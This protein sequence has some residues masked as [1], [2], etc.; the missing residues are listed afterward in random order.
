M[1]LEKIASKGS[2]K[3]KMVYHENPDEL[4]IN[5]LE[6]HAYFIPFEKGQDPFASRE[7]SNNF[8]L[9]NG[10]WGFRYF[11]S[12]ID[13]E[14]DFTK[15]AAENTIPVPA[16]WQLHGYDK[17][18]Y[19]NIAYPITFDP[20]Y[21][22]DENPVG[23]YS[24]EYEYIP[25]GKDRILVFEGVDSCLYLYV[26]DIFTGYSQVSH[27][28]SEFDITP[29]LVTGKNKITVAV[30]KWCDGTYLEDQD[31]Y[32]M[33][34]IFRD[35]YVLKRPVKRI[36][37]YVVKTILNEEKTAADLEVSVFGMDVTAKLLDPEGNAI[38]S[39]NVCDGEKGTIHVENPKLWS[40]EVP[41]LYSLMITAGEELIGEKVG[42][43]DIAIRNGVVEINGIPVK[44]RGVNRH[45]SYPDTGFYCTAE[46]M[47]MDIVLMKKHNVNA[48]RTSHYP[49]S[50]L[51]Y[52]L[53]DQYGLYVIDEGDM[54]THGCVEV[55]NDFKW[56]W[57]DGY[58]GI[59]LLASDERFKKAI[60]DRSESLVKRDINRPC[61]VF[62]SLGNESG[63]G[64]NMEAAGKLVKKLDD[65]RLLH[66]EST[67]KLDD[68]SDAVLDVVSQMY[69][70]PEDMNKFLE[71]E[72]E[73]RPF[74]LCEY[75]H[76]MGNGPG[77]LEDYHNAFHS[78]ERFCGGFVWE[79]CDHAPILGTTP[80]GKV[81]YGYGGDF[82][83]RHHDNNFCMDAL[84]YPD[85]RPHTGLLELKQVYRPIRV[86]MG[87]SATEFV[88]SSLLCQ[89]N[90]GD[91]MDYYYEISF[92]GGIT[93]SEST[94]FEIA[95]LGEKVVEVPDVLQ[96]ADKEA[97]IRFVFTAKKALTYCEKGYEICFDQ[98]ELAA[99]S[100]LKAYNEAEK[101]CMQERLCERTNAEGGNEEKN[102]HLAAK[103]REEVL[104]IDVDF[105]KVSYSY[106]RRKCCFDSIRYEGKELL[107]EAMN[108]NFFRAPI[109][110]DTMR[111]EWYRA[112]L[113]D[114]VVKGYDA[115]VSTTSRGVEIKQKQSFGWS[116]HQPIAYMD[117]VYILNA[118]GMDIYCELETGNK[119]TFLPRFGVRLF[120][121]KRFDRV[122]YYGYGPFE[123]YIDK[124]QASYMGNFEADICD[125]YED[126][127]KPQENSSHFGCK[128]V[129][130]TDGEVS[131]SFTSK[132]G[133]SFNASEYTQE[134]LATKRHNFDLVKSKSNILCVDYMMAGV[135]SNSCGPQ[136]NE[137]Y[138]LPLPMLSADFHMTID[139]L[140]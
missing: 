134:E 138:R 12:V 83:E 74:I 124:H 69:T 98:I 5:T 80:D 1:N 78:N 89:S 139:K 27:C 101:N 40:A 93:K 95:P 104:R 55:Y 52:Q 33:S 28:T 116:I 32:R 129:S 61:V 105:G 72:D 92:D 127:I 112:H 77:D 42:F 59:A 26:N 58:N 110:N 125:M 41:E 100:E 54:E 122:S 17:P 16:N 107:D 76:A 94:E 68:T 29:Y 70:S 106:N 131:L 84:T 53:C 113:N 36:Q 6:K 81:M 79:W 57:A 25:D 114:Y 7:K 123:S 2:A 45:D 111:G 46:Q 66:Y 48:V 85:R 121:P 62:W 126:Y 75:C 137:K 9:L 73:K 65:T 96:Y 31:K 24:K 82:D 38:S 71:N 109:D 97:Y 60:L 50:P 87:K 15:E 102:V 140:C 56:S 21:V 8:E 47:K 88:F 128:H 14:D 130:V 133:L 22:P 4:H 10:D 67:H 20:P 51:F 43:R 99:S 119:V 90:A 49:N 13:L 117:V 136:L 118:A 63:Y 3:S 37:N 34:G 132:N 115:E 103:I 44:F 91:F 135:G 35:V 18:Q 108:Y 19:T 23:V 39:I 120:V 64:T 11:D 30:L 86:R